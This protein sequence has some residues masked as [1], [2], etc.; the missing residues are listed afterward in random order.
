MV[1]EIKSN[2]PSV[3]YKNTG[4][5]NHP[6]QTI[7]RRP[8]TEELISL[9][10]SYIK[11]TEKALTKAP[12]GRIQLHTS[13][14][15]PRYYYYAD[16]S[17]TGKY[18][19]A[20]DILLIS[21]ICQRDYNLK[22]LN[23]LYNQLKRIEHKQQVN[24]P[25]ELDQIYHSFKKGKQSMI[26]PI[27]SPIEDYIREWY[28]LTPACQNTFPTKTI[29]LTNKG[30]QVRSKSEKIIADKLQMMDIPYI[31]EPKIV[32]NGISKY[33]DFFVL[34]VK[35]RESFIW[36]HF[37]LSDNPNYASQNLIK[38][39]LY[40]KNKLYM[41]RDVIPS[42]ETQEQPLCAELID[43]KIATFLLK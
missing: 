11:S 24:L 15:Y 3:F 35:T 34:N 43:D 23:A 1:T 8:T 38:M 41:G 27:I 29:Y 22:I 17:A 36:E 6:T 2:R 26:S 12:T 10:R 39:A 5:P 32:I 20:N 25:Y 30:E 28:S 33:P 37:G 16:N 14:G 21:S 31:Y 7:E 13:K 19:S 9:I 4:W 40:E 18:V 42:F